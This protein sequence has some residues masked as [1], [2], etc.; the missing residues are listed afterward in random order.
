[1]ALITLKFNVC[2]LETSYLLNSE[3]TDLKGRVKKCIP[4]LWY[5]CRFLAPLKC[6][7][8]HYQTVQ[9]FEGVHGGKK[10]S[11]ARGVER[12]RRAGRCCIG[13]VVVTNLAKSNSQ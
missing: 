12:H 4:A 5:S 10:L 3:V 9:V 1:M 13:V 11:L 2:K 7:Q 6:D 8:D